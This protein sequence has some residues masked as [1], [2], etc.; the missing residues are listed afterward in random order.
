MLRIVAWLFDYRLKF[1][2]SVVLV[3]EQ[4]YLLSLYSLYTLCASDV[5]IYKGDSAEFT[6][7]LIF[8]AI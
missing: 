1:I 4:V 2:Y 6:K 8:S 7:I 3:E 5:R